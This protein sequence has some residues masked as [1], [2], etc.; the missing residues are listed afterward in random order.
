MVKFNTPTTFALIPVGG[1][2]IEGLTTCNEVA[3]RIDEPT[4]H[5]GKPVNARRSGG[6][7]VW[8][9]EWEPVFIHQGR[10]LCQET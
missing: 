4:T 9:A 7:L 3:T 8:V 2:F 6:K 1:E 10:S 5:Q